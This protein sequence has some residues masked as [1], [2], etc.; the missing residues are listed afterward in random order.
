MVGLLATLF[1]HLEVV[2]ELVAHDLEASQEMEAVPP[3]VAY[4]RS[5]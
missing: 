2:V 4:H 3:A 5:L 1:V